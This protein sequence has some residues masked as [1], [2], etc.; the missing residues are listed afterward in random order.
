MVQQMA[1][2]K[3]LDDFIDCPLWC[4]CFYKRNK[5]TATARTTV[6]QNLP[7]VWIEKRVIF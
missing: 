7:D 1:N 2:V 4:S 6:G 5:L 3:G